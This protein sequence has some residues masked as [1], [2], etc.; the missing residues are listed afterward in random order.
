[1][2][3]RKT[4]PLF[5]LMSRGADS[6]PAPVSR[7]KKPVVRVELKPR[8]PSY[9]PPEPAAEERESPWPQTWAGLP[10]K[11]WSII[12]AVV[13]IVGIGVWTL[14]WSL[15]KRQGE[16]DLQPFV[17]RDPPAVV[18]PAV[19]DRTVTAL[20]PRPAQ[21]L[22]SGLPPA[23]GTDPRV[24]GLNYLYLATLPLEDARRAVNFLRE[25][26][27]DAHFLLVDPGS[28]GANNPGP[29]AKGRVFVLPGLAREELGTS[30]K[31]NLETEVV[32]LGAIWQREHRG[33]SNFEKHGWEKFK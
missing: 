21:P 31:T 10:I 3:G 32:R 4:T 27:V 30:R 29:G 12:G 9:A 18:E 33:S 25:N 6:T 13:F 5:E 1:M 8:E 14:A 15:G 17:R 7:E 22:A 23:P 24:S 11:T 28:G 2:A 19:A 16:K 26:S 20:Q